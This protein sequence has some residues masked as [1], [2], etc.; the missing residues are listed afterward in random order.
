MEC[1]RG[2]RWFGRGHVNG[3]KTRE[4]FSY[5]KRELPHKDGTTDVKWNYEKFLIDADGRPFK[6]YTIP[7]NP[8]KIQ[9]DIEHLLEVRGPCEMELKKMERMK[10]K[11]AL[12]SD[13]FMG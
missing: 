1:K 12:S 5:L 11:A 10:K 7:L 8:E 9:A 13:I 2:I 6:R 4:V 3:A